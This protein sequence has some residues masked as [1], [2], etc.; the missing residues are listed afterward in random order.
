MPGFAPK[1]YIYTESIQR[2]LLGTLVHFN[3]ATRMHGA[4]YTV[5]M[6]VCPSVLSLRLSVRLSVHLS[7]IPGILWTPLNISSKFYYSQVAPPL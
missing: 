1:Q 2:K 3:R 5:A 6:S 4:D 7:V